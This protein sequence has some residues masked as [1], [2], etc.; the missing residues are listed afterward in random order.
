MSGSLAKGYLDFALEQGC[1]TTEQFEHVLAS[2]P[3]VHAALEFAIDRSE[4]LTVVGPRTG[5]TK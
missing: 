3:N 4:S 2:N 1:I 5:N